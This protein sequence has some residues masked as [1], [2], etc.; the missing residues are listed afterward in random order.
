MV[1][2]RSTKEKQKEKPLQ[3][4]WF[5]FVKNCDKKI[6]YFYFCEILVKHEHNK[7][8]LMDWWFLV[9]LE[10][11][12]PAAIR[13]Y[14]QAVASCRLYSALQVSIHSHNYTVHSYCT[15]YSTGGQ[16]NYRCTAAIRPLHQEV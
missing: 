5:N 13:L 7:Y 15:V 6:V 8:R 2:L 12:A 14:H 9:A 16:Y 1:F 10:T 11:A 4:W 3:F